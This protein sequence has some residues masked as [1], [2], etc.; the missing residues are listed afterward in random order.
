MFKRPVPLGAIYHAASKR[1]REVKLDESL[2]S[3]VIET[4]QNVRSMIALGKLPAPVADQRCPD[5]SLIDACMP[6]ALQDFERSAK[7]NNLFSI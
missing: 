4:T 1:R 5:C 3:I 7:S 2:R 6:Y